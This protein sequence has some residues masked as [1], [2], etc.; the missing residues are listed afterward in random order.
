[1]LHAAMRAVPSN[2]PTRGCVTEDSC[3]SKRP[4]GSVPALVASRH[5]LISN[6]AR[7]MAN[8]IL[9]VRAIPA[10]GMFMSR[11]NSRDDASCK[12]CL[13]GGWLLKFEN[14]LVLEGLD[15]H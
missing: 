13:A 11:H 5:L 4:A 14:R 12:G 6:V 15:P 9:P 10:H 3:C 2:P 7:H 1:M 8:V